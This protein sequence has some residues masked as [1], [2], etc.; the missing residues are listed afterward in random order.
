MFAARAVLKYTCDGPPELANPTPAERRKL[1]EEYELI[2]AKGGA[3]DGEAM[4]DTEDIIETCRDLGIFAKGPNAHLDREGRMNQPLSKRSEDVQKLMAALDKDGSG[5][6]SFDEFL[7]A[8]ATG[9]ERLVKLVIAFDKRRR[10]HQARHGPHA[11][12][13]VPPTA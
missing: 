3:D 5:S 2:A 7:H 8:L 12:R 1:R 9:E 11:R 13:I 10:R 6:I 4:V